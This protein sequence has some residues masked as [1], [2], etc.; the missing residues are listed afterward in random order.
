MEEVRSALKVL[1]GKPTGKR[2]LVRLRRI[3]DY[4]IRMNLKEMYVNTRNWID[5]AHGIDY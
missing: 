2:P 4:N 3:R 5:S 1:T